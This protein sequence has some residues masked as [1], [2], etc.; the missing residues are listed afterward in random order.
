MP[1][2]EIKPNTL[3]YYLWEQRMTVQEFADMTSMTPVGVYGMLDGFKAIR[4]E[5]M[6]KI[7]KATKEKTGQG[8]LPQEYINIS[9]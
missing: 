9:S 3:R 4:V 6:Q 7:F 2:K 1:K 8:L 5:T